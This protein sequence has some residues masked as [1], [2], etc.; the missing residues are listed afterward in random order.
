MG[1]RNGDKALAAKCLEQAL[2]KHHEDHRDQRKGKLSRMN[3][4]MSLGSC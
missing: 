3:C 1:D 4:T 2:A